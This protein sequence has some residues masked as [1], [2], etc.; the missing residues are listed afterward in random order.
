MF[1]YQVAVYFSYMLLRGFARDMLLPGLGLKG[2]REVWVLG[3]YIA[4]EHNKR[5]CRTCLHGMEVK[6]HTLTLIVILSGAQGNL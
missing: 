3:V 6:I 2:Q 1:L 5:E 4:R